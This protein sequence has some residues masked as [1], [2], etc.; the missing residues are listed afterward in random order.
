MVEA[1]ARGYLLKNT[2]R[3]ELTV[4]IKEVYNGGRYYCKSISKLIGAEY[5]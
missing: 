1:G 2:H 3:Q 4:A 5:K